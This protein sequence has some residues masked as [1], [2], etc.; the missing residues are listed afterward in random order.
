V[1][2]ALLGVAGLRH[3]GP[4]LVIDAPGRGARQAGPAPCYASSNRG[5]IMSRAAGVPLFL[6]VAIVVL[7]GCSGS[8]PAAPVPTAIVRASLDAQVASTGAAVARSPTVVVTDG[9]GQ[10]VPGVTVAWTVLAGSGEVVSPATT[11]GT[12][13]TASVAWT[14]GPTPGPNVLSASVGGLAPVHFDAFAVRASP[15]VVVGL[16]AP[17]AGTVVGDSV[18]VQATV[19]STFQLASVVAGA[20]DAT[21]SLAL[22]AGTWSAT[23]D[24]RGVSSGRRWLAVTATDVQGAVADAAA[25]L[26]LDRRPIVS[27]T[28]PAPGALATPTLEL[29]ATCEDDEARG[30]AS[31]AVTVGDLVRSAT[32]TLAATLDLSPWDAGEVTLTFTGTDTRGQTS[33][34]TRRVFVVTSPSLELTR[35]LPGTAWDVSGTRFLYVDARGTPPSLELLD[36]SG[37]APIAID[38]DA[39]LEWP[40]ATPYGFLTAAGAVYAKAP[41]VASSE[42]Y[43]AH[44]WRGSGAPVDLGWIDASGGPW[45]RVAGGY[46]TYGPP[47]LGQLQL[48]DLVSGTSAALP[49]YWTHG[50]SDVAANGDVVFAAVASGDASNVYRSRGGSV[51]V[52]T[53]GGGVTTPLTDGT[54]VVYGVRTGDTVQIVLDDATTVT[55]LATGPVVS[56]V[57][58]YAI[59]NGWVAYLKPDLDGVGQAWRHHGSM[60]EQLTQFATTPAIDLVASDG[61]VYLTSGSGPVGRRRHRATPGAALEELGIAT[62][63]VVER[64]GAVFLLLGP[65]VLRYLP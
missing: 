30:C 56:P 3:G 44:D 65:H 33:V 63:R 12:D 26:T 35:T 64:D 10:P 50:L 61:T 15:R 31:L 40:G 29:A 37:G 36:T 48:R 5:E 51:T 8:G 11:T 58:G 46:A 9:G 54:G 62:G 25:S 52:L 19:S 14:L 59:A 55:T 2:H 1:R 16:S 34:V 43:T 57:S 20:G 17:G 41:S 4:P 18:T 39:L 32:T 49:A 42:N 60:E 38:S 21:A 28:S 22:S 7:A 53:T 23:L 24:L 47:R 13:G 27:V 6:S 45:L